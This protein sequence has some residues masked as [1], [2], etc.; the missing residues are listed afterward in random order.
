M[1]D[2][3]RVGI[4]GK[5]LLKECQAV[6]QQWKLINLALVLGV[7]TGCQLL[8][9]QSADIATVNSREGNLT[10]MTLSSHKESKLVELH[11]S[12]GIACEF[13]QVNGVDVIDPVT[14]RPMDDA[15]K[16]SMIR[17]EEAGLTQLNHA[18]YYVAMQAGTS[19]VRVRFYPVTQDRAENFT[20]IHNFRPT[21]KYQVKLFRQRSA[22]SASLLSIA[23]PGTLCV[24]L[25]EDDQV[26]RRF[27]RP[28]DPITGLGEFV[29]QR[30]NS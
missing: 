5:T 26:N 4:T 2:A 12:G 16:T 13:A 14:R 6:M 22:S 17:Y 15:L 10:P 20:L 23:A 7:M 18:Q 21:K 11:C 1:R 19:E 30:V 8:P 9:N 27:C 3:S 25:L 28:F 24:D 29:E